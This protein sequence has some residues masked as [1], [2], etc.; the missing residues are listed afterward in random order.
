MLD[1]LEDID[2]GPGGEVLISGEVF[3]DEFAPVP[4]PCRVTAFYRGVR[5]AL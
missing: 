4:V 3:V 2:L 5:I 1:V